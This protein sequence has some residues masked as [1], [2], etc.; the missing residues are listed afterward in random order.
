VLL[1]LVAKGLL[2][3]F[4][5]SFNDDKFRAVIRFL[6]DKISQTATEYNPAFARNTNREHLEDPEFIFEAFSYREKKLLLSVSDRMRNY[7]KKR[8]D[9][10]KAFLKCQKHLIELSKA[11][12]DRMALKSLYK[13]IKQCDSDAEKSI[14]KKLYAL[15]GLSTIHENSAFYLE[16]DFMLGVKSKA[17]RR[18]VG[19][20]CQE[21]RN[22][23]EG[24]VDA[25][26][27]PEELLGAKIILYN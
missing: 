26:L 18:L 2:T 24:L 17:I 16:N 4:Q 12:V 10:Y 23:A 13:Q 21:M 15:Y 1:Q 3:K 11:Y 5:K 14:L 9:P 6:G 7:L 8:I 19:K 27:I 20:I 22:D 25:F